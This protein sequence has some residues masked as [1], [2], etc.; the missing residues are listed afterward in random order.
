[1]KKLFILSG[2]CLLVAGCSIFPK[3]Q[4]PPVNHFSMGKPNGQLVEQR[5]VTVQPVISLTGYSSQ[6]LFKAVEGKVEVDQ[7]NRWITPPTTQV[8]RYL[9][10]AMAAKSNSDIKQHTLIL[11]SKLLT[12]E[13]DLSSKSVN[14]TL[15]VTV[16]AKNRIKIEQLFSE[17]VSVAD[18]TATGYAVAMNKAMDKIAIDIASKINA[19]K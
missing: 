4:T 5:L 8:Q 13:C 7:F 10:I 14:L 3:P 19:L 6:M 18:N 15:L 17:K 12:F 11:S 1:M 2:L 16:K 9:T